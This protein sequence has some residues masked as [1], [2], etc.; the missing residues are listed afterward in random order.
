MLPTD[1]DYGRWPKSGEIDIMEHVGY[2]QDQIHF[3]AHTQKYNHTKNTE[4]TKYTHV[5]GVSDGFHK[6]SL[7]WFPDK[8]KFYVDDIVRFIYSPN[9][10]SDLQDHSLWPFD[11]RF[12]LVLNVAIGGFWGGVEGV[13]DSIFPQ[14]M[15][16]DYVRVYQADEL[17]NFSGLNI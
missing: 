5:D 14:E 10:K 2:N 12:H 7:E 1:N 17:M 13:D 11:K 15:E 9:E 16:I 6:Y 3:S 4:I 8:L